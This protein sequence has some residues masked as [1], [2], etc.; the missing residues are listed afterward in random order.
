MPGCE[1]ATHLR[2]LFLQREL[3]D[4]PFCSER[5]DVDSWTRSATSR[6]SRLDLLSSAASTVSATMSATAGGGARAPWR[7]LLERIS[8]R[9]FWR[10]CDDLLYDCVKVQQMLDLV[11]SHAARRVQPLLLGQIGNDLGR[12]TSFGRSP[13]REL[14]FQI[15]DEGVLDSWPATSP[16]CLQR[17][18]FLRLPDLFE[19]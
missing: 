2:G 11:A 18:F 13:L 6:F 3:L 14:A 16:M 10:C 5:F 4:V 15:A 12:G 19:E 1:A 17:Y 7:T 8:T 9:P